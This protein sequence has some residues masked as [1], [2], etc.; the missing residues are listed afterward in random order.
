[1]AVLNFLTFDIN[2]M[3]TVSESNVALLSPT[4]VLIPRLPLFLPERSNTISWMQVPSMLAFHEYVV[5]PQS[6]R[7]PVVG[8]QCLFI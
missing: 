7:L 1:M 5:R 3:V 6:G 4:S 2:S 8:C